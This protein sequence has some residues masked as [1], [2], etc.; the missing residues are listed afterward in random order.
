MDLL[1][2]HSTNESGISELKHLRPTGGKGGTVNA[3]TKGNKSGASTPMTLLTQLSRL[4]DIAKSQ[5]E[6]KFKTLAHLLNEEMLSRS[7]HTLRKNA[8]AGVDE[9]TAQEY[10]KNLQQNITDLYRRLRNNQYRAQHLRRVYI[11]KEDGKQRPLSIPALEDKIVQRGIAEILNRIYEQDFLDCSYG[12]RP[13]RG[14]Q[15]AISF[16]RERALTRVRFILEAD[17]KDYF[18]SIVR[19]LLMEIIKK[20]IADKKILQLI[21]KWLHVGVIEDGKLF[22][23][24]DG[25]YQGSIISPILA[26]IY[27]HEVL[28]TWVEKTVK[29]YLRGEI[30]LCR[31]ADD[32]VVE[33]EYKDDAIR[34]KEVLRKRF[35][36]YGLTLHEDKTK[37]VEFGRFAKENRKGK[38][39][40]TITFLGFTFYCSTSRNGHFTVRVKTAAKRLKRSLSRVSKYCKENRHIP[41]AAQHKRL[42]E[43]MKGHYQYY[44]RRTNT[45]SLKKYHWEVIRTWHR[46]LCR[47]SRNGY[48]TW[49]DFNKLLGKYPLPSPRITERSTGQQFSF[50]L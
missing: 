18:G 11:E 16:V 39:P 17:I 36:K 21:G 6:F 14:A 4:S 50:E 15:Q 38:R 46:W 22:M 25:T 20:R 28:D 40:E 31:F 26:N 2:I 5:P 24:K 9:V 23:T 10:E 48:I 13:K 27:L 30:Y 33:C 29:P 1:R 49:P 43:M 37:L 12:Y 19:K 42:S 41:L 8:A 47:R 32:F 7:F 3:T 34:F 45:T 44:G 35:A